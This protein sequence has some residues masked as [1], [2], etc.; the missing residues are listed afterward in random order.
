MKFILPCIAFALLFFSICMKASGFS[1]DEQGVILAEHIE[2]DS[3][4][5]STE[6]LTVRKVSRHVYVHTSYLHT[7]S[8]GK[9]SCNG[10]VVVNSKEAI[11]FDT[12]AEEKSSKE[13]IELFEKMGINIQAVIATHFHADCVGGLRAFHSSGIKS[14]ANSLTIQLLKELPEKFDIPENGFKGTLELKLGDK[15][16]IVDF[17]GEG[18]T[19]DNVIGYFPDE[20]ILFGG[21]LIKEIGAGKGNLE[22]ANVNE[23]SNT[24]SKV[25][26]KYAQTRIVIPGHGKIGG[27]E[28]LDYTIR[29]FQ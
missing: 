11:V 29:L 6:S 5:Y 21:C 4:I 12:P 1:I 16:I 17:L 2:G 19:K 24:V 28:L 26:N 3:L 13:L 27:T 8:F 9:V 25:K 7:N 22:D 20:K 14:Y 10:M 23:W 15:N 18:H